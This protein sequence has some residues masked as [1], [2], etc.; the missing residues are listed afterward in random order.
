MI[1][2]VI[3]FLIYWVGKVIVWDVVSIK[4]IE[5]VIVKVVIMEKSDFKSVWVELGWV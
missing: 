4:V 2:S 5:W 1:D 3:L